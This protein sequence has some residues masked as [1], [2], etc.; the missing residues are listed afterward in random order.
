MYLSS[1]THGKSTPHSLRLR[2]C[3]PCC[4]N[5]VM[6][7]PNIDTI[8]KK[9][10]LWHNRHSPHRWP[11][12]FPATRCNYLPFLQEHPHQRCPVL[13]GRNS[14][15]SDHRR[16]RGYFYFLIGFDQEF[17]SPFSLSSGQYRQVD[18]FI[19]ETIEIDTYRHQ[20]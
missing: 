3:L 13:N 8:R 10:F 18:T 5:V 9:I 1:S 16:R 6:R 4:I 14:I 15:W 20:S 17:F 2:C 12:K 11:Q 7:R 19:K